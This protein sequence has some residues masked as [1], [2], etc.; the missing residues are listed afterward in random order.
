MRC[1]AEVTCTGVETAGVGDGAASEEL[2]AGDSGVCSSCRFLPNNQL[3]IAARG[4]GI[5]LVYLM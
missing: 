5:D 2:P 1:A 4:V 3:N